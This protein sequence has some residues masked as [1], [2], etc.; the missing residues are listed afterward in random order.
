M[1]I[2]IYNP[3]Q[4][5]P[6][7]PVRWNY[8]DLKAQL[9]EA[10]ASYKGVI[11]TEDTIQDAKKDR[12]KLNKLA[13]AIDTR[14]KQMKEKYLA[15]YSRFEEQAKELTAL[16]KQQSDEI[17]AQVK[18]YDEA[19]RAEK[20]E[21][22]KALYAEIMRDYAQ[23]VPYEKI[24]N[25]KWLNVTVSMAAIEG[26]IIEKAESVRAALAS[27]DALG[28]SGEMES[29]VKAAYLE[30]LDLPYAL[31]K[32]EEIER[33]QQALEY[34]RQMKKCPVSAPE[35]PHSERTESGNEITPAKEESAAQANPV[36]DSSKS[37]DT[38]TVDFRVTATAAQL[39]ALK[40]FLRNNGIKYGPCT[41]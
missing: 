21:H 17:S 41:R 10:L 31:R 30:R 39:A 13:D 36:A 26:E 4:G 28:L 16:I 9:T 8:E 40:A 20:Q 38:Y 33:Q 37:E 18:A 22:I 19:R 24:H 7:P 1:Q 11:Y 29:V 25:P 6:L 23:A 5:E 3:A 32:K 27:I 35:Q 12:A 34:L 15:P 2:E 14:R